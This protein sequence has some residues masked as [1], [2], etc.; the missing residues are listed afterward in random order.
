MESM[1]PPVEDSVTRLCAV[2]MHVRWF[3]TSSLCSRGVPRSAV[4]ATSFMY[5]LVLLE[6]VSTW[7]R[8][9][10]PQRNRGLTDFSRVYSCWTLP[11]VLMRSIFLPLFLT[12]CLFV[13]TGLVFSQSKTVMLMVLML[14]MTRSRMAPSP[15][16]K[17]TAIKSMF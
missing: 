15:C 7:S 16:C 3:K 14:T 5:M 10:E 4:G 1:N 11:G 17:R 13:P 12:I 2:L 9:P 6:I 8:K